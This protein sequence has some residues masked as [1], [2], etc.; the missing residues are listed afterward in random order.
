MVLL[1]WGYVLLGLWAGRKQLTFSI[2]PPP[3]LIWTSST[4]LA[5]PHQYGESLS[6]QPRWILVAAQAA[7]LPPPP[8]P[9][10]WATERPSGA[11]VAPLWEEAGAADSQLVV[12]PRLQHGHRTGVI[13]TIR[14]SLS[15]S[16]LQS[17]RL[18]N[19]LML[20]ASWH[21]VNLTPICNI[22]GIWQKLWELLTA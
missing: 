5:A 3:V 19:R 17:L 13:V 16:E 12:K 6:K 22:L 2:C 9:P 15:S 4:D 7:A 18:I 20:S 10:H 8:T 1:I 11:G 21:S 14:P